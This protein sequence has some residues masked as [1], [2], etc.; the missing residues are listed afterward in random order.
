M[1]VDAE[2]EKRCIRKKG[3]KAE[4]PGQDPGS[5]LRWG[6]IL[7]VLVGGAFDLWGKGKPLEHFKQHGGV[8]RLV[9]YKDRTDIGYWTTVGEDGSRESRREV[10]VASYGHDLVMATWW[11]PGPSLW[12]WELREVDR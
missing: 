3:R 10:L 11:W 1:C 5:G 8:V 6:W 9:S 7:P 4:A 12:Q 2:P